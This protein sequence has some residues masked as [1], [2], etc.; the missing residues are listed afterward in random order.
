[1][2]IDRAWLSMTLNETS[3]G[4]TGICGHK[5]DLFEPNTA[6]QWIADYSAILTK[7][8]AN[9]NKELGRLADF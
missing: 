4:I 7:A 5:N 9:P 3:S 8:A 1:M 6:Q 2:P